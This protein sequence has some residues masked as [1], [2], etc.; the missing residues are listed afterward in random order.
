M[1]D[2]NFDNLISATPG[3]VKKCQYPT[4]EAEIPNDSQFNY[5]E[6]CR[7]LAA[8]N[9]VALIFDPCVPKEMERSKE[10]HHT[11]LHNMTGDEI[12]AYGK[13]IETAYLD[14]QKLIRINNIVS[15]ARKPFKSLS[16]QVEEAR[17]IAEE[18]S[19]RAKTG[20]KS[21]Q[22][23]IS[24]VEKMQK[25]MG[26]DEKKAKELLGESFDDLLG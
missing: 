7:I 11:M 2:Q 22:K 3:A 26:V 1:T 9:A 5:C 23:K 15:S 6:K 12:L 17:A 10:V 19:N 21:A 14:I 16:E 13:K 20:K 24:A 18:S 4:C 8:R 25:L